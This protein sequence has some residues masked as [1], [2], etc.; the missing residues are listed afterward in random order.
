MGPAAAVRSLNDPEAMGELISAGGVHTLLALTDPEER[1][2]SL[3]NATPYLSP[4][5]FT[6]STVW[7]LHPISELVDAHPEDPEAVVEGLRDQG[8]SLLLVH[9]G[10]L[11]NWSRSGWLDPDL[12]EGRLGP[13]LERLVPEFAW[14]NGEILF[15]IPPRS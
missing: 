8:W 15:R 5:P 4:R 10:M 9:R 6:Y 14:P 1:I 13:I 3:G 7:D 12:E 11:D 2:L